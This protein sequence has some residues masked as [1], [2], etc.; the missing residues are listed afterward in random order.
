MRG[1]DIPE[2]L[3]FNDKAWNNHEYLVKRFKDEADVSTVPLPPAQLE[4]PVKELES[5]KKYY[6]QVDEHLHPVIERLDRKHQERFERLET[7]AQ[8]SRDV[9]WWPFTQH[10]MVKEVTVIDSAYNDHMYTYAPEAPGKKEL[11][12]KEM[13]DA[14]AS[15]WTQGLGHANPKLTLAAAY[16]AGRYGHVMFP[17]ATNEPA[18]KLAEAMLEQNDWAQRVFFSDNGS[19]AMEVAIKMAIRSTTIRYGW[20]DKL[21]PEIIGLNGSYHGDTI[22]AMD[23]CAPNVYNGQ[24]QWYQPRG[25]WYD[26]PTVQTRR[27]KVVVTIPDEIKSKQDSVSY[28]SLGSLFDPE[29]LENDE[30]KDVYQRFIRQSLESLSSQGRK[31]GALLM[32][33]VLMGSG[34][35][36]V[37]DP[38]FQKALVDVVRKDGAELLGNGTQGQTGEWQGLP[39]VIDEVF[40]GMY[41]LGRSRASSYLGVTPDIAAYAKVLTGGLIPLALTITTDSIFNNFLSDNKADCLLHGHSYTAH[42]MGCAVA[43]ASIDIL[44]QLNSDGS[45]SHYKQDWGVKANENIWSMWNKNTVDFLS[46]LPNVQGVNAIG[47]VLAVELKDAEGR[48][49]TSAASAKI[50]AKMRSHE[51]EHTNINMFARPLGNVIYVMASQRTRPEQIK[52]LE[53]TLLQ[54]LE[55]EL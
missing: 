48:G 39:I 43:K 27:G 33:P 9:F 45:W 54:C 41:R 49:Y 25:H 44:E 4:D 3:L 46:H 29:R 2:I 50:I 47:S 10:D 28:E 18:L 24:V 55:E 36:V 11:Q 15:W 8:K 32:E 23:A 16:A 7:M 42:P 22:G 31:F 21:K 12:P 34:G 40:A 5:M 37:S 19:T 35:M 13:F 14:C 52:V 51:F 53:Q 26:P 6:E 20:D 17:E 1:Y 38:L 30:L